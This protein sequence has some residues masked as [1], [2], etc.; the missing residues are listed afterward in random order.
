VIVAGVVDLA[1]LAGTSP[2]GVD[3][4]TAASEGLVVTSIGVVTHISYTIICLLKGNIAV[5]AHQPSGPYGR[6]GWRHSSCQAVAFWAPRFY[7]ERKLAKA[8]L[9]DD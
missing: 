5:G 7:S 6:L 3:P 1:L 4:A 9:A 8:A 2:I